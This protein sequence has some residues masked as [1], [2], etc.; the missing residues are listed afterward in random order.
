MLMVAEV[1]NANAKLYTHT[2]T[3]TTVLLE[4]FQLCLGGYPKYQE[5]LAVFCSST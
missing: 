1:V 4:I 2:Q 3:Q 5:T